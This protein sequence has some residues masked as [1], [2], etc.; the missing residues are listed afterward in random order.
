ME[1]YV[2]AICESLR[3][4]IRRNRLRRVLVPIFESGGVRE[5]YAFE[6]PNDLWGD[7]LE[8]SFK[9]YVVRLA[10]LLQ[11]LRCHRFAWDLP[12]EFRI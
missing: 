5:R 9:T 4:A 11:N 3:P 8:A 6:F 7:F 10:L 1:K 12:S 2:S